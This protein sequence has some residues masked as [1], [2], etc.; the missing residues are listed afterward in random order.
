MPT[1]LLDIDVFSFL[2][3]GDTRASA[4]AAH[5]QGHRLALS[6]MTVAELFQWAA[7]RTWGP[8]RLAQLE[9]TLIAYLIVPADIEMCRIW[10]R[11]RAERQAVGRPLS[12]QD[13]WIAATALRHTIPL[14]TH[15]VGDYQGIAALDMRTVTQP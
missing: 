14:V 13:A 3:K 1:V 9:Q 10:G 12:P 7:V 6:F 5:I 15:N 8:R 2:L 4:Y 11:L